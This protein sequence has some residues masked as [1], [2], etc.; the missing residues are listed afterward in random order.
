MFNM[1]RE[2]SLL[3]PDW[4]EV[5]WN[6]SGLFNYRLL[7]GFLTQMMKN[8]NIS[9]VLESFHDAPDLI[10][11]GGRINAN[12]RNYDDAAEYFKT[13]NNQGIG[14]FLTFS[15]AV[16]EEKHLSDPESN[17]L[18][19]C[20]DEACGL[21]SVIVVSDLMSDYVRKKKPGL[22]QICSIVKS[23]IENPQG[24]IEW[25][26]EMQKRFD[27]VVVHTDHMFDL[28]LLDKL[29]RSKAE[30]LVTEECVYKCPN[31]KRHQ[32]LNSIYNIAKAEDAARAEEVFEEIGKIRHDSCA[33]GQA[34]L[35]EEKNPKQ[36]R[37]CYLM[38]DEV[39]TIYD[40]GFR[41]FK[42]S[43]RRRTIYGLAWNVI[44]FVFNPD[45]RYVF[46]RMLY[47]RIDQKVKAEFVE[48]AQKKG[49]R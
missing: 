11:N 33:G 19:E 7:V 8:L 48:V 43:G 3:H 42:I 17:R 16:L 49:V 36:M 30:I 25:Y 14:V 4:P 13:L 29:D 28:E 12:V 37:S 35:S 26:Q 38:H 20:L 5:K 34:V 44:N 41:Y 47:T 2:S 31:R 24:D 21:N 45:L 18:L 9:H 32:T 22:K 40:M 6:I 46:A 23:F 15:N 27:R 10:W 1:Q 39:K